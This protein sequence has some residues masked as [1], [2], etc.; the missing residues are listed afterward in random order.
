MPVKRHAGKDV[1]P[2]PLLLD[3][4]RKA[5]PVPVKRAPLYK[6]AVKPT[7]ALAIFFG[8]GGV[9]TYRLLGTV[10]TTKVLQAAPFLRYVL[11]PQSPHPAPQP[12]D[13]PARGASPSSS[14]ADPRPAANHALPATTGSSGVLS[15]LPPR[16]SLT[17]PPP[18]LTTHT[19]QPPASLVTPHHATSPAPS[20]PAPPQVPV[21]PVPPDDPPH[22]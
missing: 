22:P 19:P 12:A 2:K 13:D 10:D 11:P 8:V 1:S 9:L 7:L 3:R 4:A 20:T 17:P 14:A 15:L 18:Q 6:R 5:R 21:T 16:R